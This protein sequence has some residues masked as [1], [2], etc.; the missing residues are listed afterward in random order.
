MVAQLAQF[1]A[2]GYGRDVVVAPEDGE[3]VASMAL[4]DRRALGELYGRYAPLCLAVGRRILGDQ[5]ESEEVMH[6]VFVEAFRAASTYRSERGSVCTWLTVRMRS[7]CLDRAKS[8]GRARRVGLDDVA[9]ARLVTTPA[10]ATGDER[11]IAELLVALPPEQRL[12]IELAY[13]DGLSS[14]EIAE[15]V[16]VALGTV[17][18]R[19]A[20]ALAKLR[21]A[22][23]AG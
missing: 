16:G 12:V 22:M 21:A 13:F 9:P 8:A 23:G 2:T 7:R 4:G 18:S 5:A 20:A 3:L 11:R 19:T 14:S 1:P 10:R 6:E 15:R 17:K